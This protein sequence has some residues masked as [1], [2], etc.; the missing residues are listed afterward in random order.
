MFNIDFKY[1]FDILKNKFEIL[2]KYGKSYHD[3]ITYYRYTKAI[4]ESFEQGKA[5]LELI[6]Q[7]SYFC[8][9]ENISYRAISFLIK[10]KNKYNSLEI[11]NYFLIQQYMN[12][13][14]E[15][16][17]KETQAVVISLLKESLQHSFGNR[18]FKLLANKIS[19]FPNE[20]SSQYIEGINR[21]D[22]FGYI[23]HNIDSVRKKYV[24][25]I[26][27]TALQQNDY[28]FYLEIRDIY[29]YLHE[30]TPELIGTLK[31]KN[32]LLSC[33]TLD[34]ISGV[35]SDHTK[36]DRIIK[37]HKEFI[38]TCTFSTTIYEKIKR[39][40]YLGAAPRYLS[41]SFSRIHEPSYFHRIMEWNLEVLNN[42][43]YRPELKFMLV[44]FFEKIRASNLCQ[45]II[46]EKHY[47]LCQGDFQISNILYLPNS[48][49]FLIVDWANCTFAPKLLDIATLFVE[50]QYSYQTIL[51]FFLEEIEYS[52]AY[53]DIDIVLFFLTAIT[54]SL[55]KRPFTYINEDTD[56][57]F[58]PAVNNCLGLL[59][60]IVANKNEYI[61][62]I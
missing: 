35:P 47:S 17:N 43:A 55:M 31:S 4:E 32:G 27:I 54:I 22:N 16:L 57:F 60:K 25:K 50:A 42:Q 45:Y 2:F 41:R 58:R 29:P 19:V 3:D 46:P 9:H 40:F 44:M 59:D 10:I 28:L 36:L 48:E 38:Q 24:T 56:K 1:K 6:Y 15:H 49:K 8:S 21:S 30:I 33:L 51:D 23:L 62:E 61:S 39:P 20:V 37:C 53:D 26:S 5:D 18:L 14:L 52:E 13:L 7:F 34:F 12:S 11:C